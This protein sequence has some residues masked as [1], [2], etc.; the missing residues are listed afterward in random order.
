MGAYVC[1][2]TCRGQL[3]SWYRVVG[4][5]GRFAGFDFYECVTEFTFITEITLADTFH[6][7]SMLTTIHSGTGISKPGFLPHEEHT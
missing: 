2:T 6:A 4:H 7:R 5:A 3:P 1:L